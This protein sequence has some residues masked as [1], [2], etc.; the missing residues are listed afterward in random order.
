[1]TRLTTFVQTERRTVARWCSGENEPTGAR[2]IRLRVF[3][4]TAGYAVDEFNTPEP[5]RAVTQIAAIGL[6]TFAEL[7]GALGYNTQANFY[8]VLLGKDSAS[9]KRLV[10]FAQIADR[11]KERLASAMAAL[12][13]S[14][15]LRAEKDVFA[16]EDKPRLKH[17][18]GSV[19]VREGEVIDVPS[20]IKVIAHLV[21]A[22]YPL[23]DV[24]ERRA[25]ATE[26]E[27]LRG[28]TGDTMRLL[29]N[30]LHRLAGGDKARAELPRAT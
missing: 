11:Y 28:L 2:L 24:L 3:L 13:A 5:V 9:E 6:S 21:R 14:I 1:M 4:D 17:L 18:G 19:G 8:S 7:S 29:A 20:L 30:R 22:L 16:S 25:S 15:K 12:R 23:A 27:Q 26:R 10:R